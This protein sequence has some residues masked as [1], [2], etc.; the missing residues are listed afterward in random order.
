MPANSKLKNLNSPLKYNLQLIALEFGLKISIDTILSD[1]YITHSIIRVILTP[2][3]MERT[4][5]IP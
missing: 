2:N 1:N 3:V 4:T 5:L